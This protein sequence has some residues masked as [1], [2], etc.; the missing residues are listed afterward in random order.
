M[1]ERGKIVRQHDGDTYECR[2]SDER[3]FYIEILGYDG[4]EVDIPFTLHRFHPEHGESIQIADNE[5][6]GVVV[7]NEY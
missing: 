5:F 1:V 7:Q 2:M 6:L 4:C 3:V